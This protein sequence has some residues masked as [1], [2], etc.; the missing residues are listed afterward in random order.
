M[1][2]QFETGM[3][4]KSN[5]NMQFFPG[6][7]LNQLYNPYIN[8][9]SNINKNISQNQM[10]MND[11]PLLINTT[12]AN[13]MNY[14]YQN[15]NYN[16]ISYPQIQQT[17]NSPIQKQSIDKPNNNSNSLPKINNKENTQNKSQERKSSNNKNN[18]K[19]NTNNNNNKK[20]ENDN[21]KANNN[22]IKLNNK[23]FIINKPKTTSKSNI[24]GEKQILNSSES[25][26]KMKSFESFSLDE[27][28]EALDEIIITEYTKNEIYKDLNK[29][30][31]D[32]NLK[33]NYYEVVS[34]F[35]A[36]LIYSLNKYAT[37]KNAFEKTKRRI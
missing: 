2:K 30:L 10:N 3:N 25:D 31:R 33:K 23:N 29:W 6:L 26:K 32:F 37:E 13:P 34:Y 28:I 18:L 4:Y 15:L 16:I 24:K 5:N 21:D 17:I 1:N 36:R 9:M 20:C 12:P 7:Y 35:T 19:L 27:K 14:N 11:L 22:S 8:N